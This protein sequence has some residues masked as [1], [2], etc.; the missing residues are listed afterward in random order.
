MSFVL[1]I[2]LLVFVIGTFLK[3]DKKIAIYTSLDNFEKRHGSS[4]S[5]TISL[6]IKKAKQIK[7]LLKIIMNYLHKMFIH[8]SSS[9]A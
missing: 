8:L 9:S 5:P 1:M 4:K 6:S 2:Y 3:Q 7:Y